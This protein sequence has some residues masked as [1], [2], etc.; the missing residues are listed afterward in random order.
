MRARSR[1][2][3]RRLNALNLMSDLCDLVELQEVSV[4]KV[5]R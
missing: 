3:L 4:S 1:F 2:L 5:V